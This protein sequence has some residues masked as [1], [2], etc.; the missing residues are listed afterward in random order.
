MFWCSNVNDIIQK[1]DTINM[2][3]LKG[4]VDY[5][6]SEKKNFQIHTKPLKKFNQKLIEHANFLE[7]K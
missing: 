2:R 5:L 3:N 4:Y 7:T 1:N 6:I